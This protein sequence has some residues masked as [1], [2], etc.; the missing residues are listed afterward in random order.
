MIGP[1]DE[2]VNPAVCA[3]LTA[4]SRARNGDVAIT[5]Y[6]GATHDFDD[7][8]ANRRGRYANAIAWQNAAGRATEF[9]A[10]LLRG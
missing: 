9:F 5:F 8:G 6:P 7:P 2:E 4:R 1:A 3:E 10:R